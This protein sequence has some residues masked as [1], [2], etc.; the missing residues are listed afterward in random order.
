MTDT[1]NVPNHSFTTARG[2]KV[3]VFAVKKMGE[4]N[5]FRG[6]GVTVGCFA[7]VNETDRVEVDG[8]VTAAFRFVEAAGF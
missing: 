8:R 6:C 4:A 1:M 5:G 7:M 2:N 3:R